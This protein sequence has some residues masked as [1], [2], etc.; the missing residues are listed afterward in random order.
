MALKALILRKKISEKKAELNTLRTAAA[1]FETREAEIAAS[2]EE[3]HT[4]EEKTV[5]EEA[6]DTFEKEKSENAEKDKALAD[7]IE[8]LENELKELEDAAPVATPTTET[9]EVRKDV[10]FMEL[11][12]RTKFSAMTLEQRSAF[13]ARDEIKEFVTRARDLLLQNRSVSG[14]ELTIPDNVLEFMRLEIYEGSKLIKHVCS[15]SVKGTARQNIMGDIPEAVWTEADGKIN[16]LNF[17]IS[18]AEVDGY[19]VA[20]FVAIPN[21]TIEDSDLALLSELIAATGRSIGIALDKAIL[22]GDGKKKP[23]GIVTRLSQTTKP[24]SYPVKAREWVDLH[25]SNIKKLPG[26]LS[27]AGFFA[28]LTIAAAA[29]KS[30]NSISGK[31]W[32]M[33]ETTKATIL[34]KGIAFN[35]AGAIVAAM[36]DRMPIVDGDIET[37][38]FIPDNDIIGGY[39]EKYLLAERSGATFALSEHAQ[40]VDDNTLAKGVA[41][42][43]GLPVIAESFVVI[44]INNAA[45]GTETTFAPDTANDASLTKLAIGSETLAPEFNS[46]K[47]EYTVT[48]SGTSA[49]IVATAT[50]A[51]AKV[52]LTYDGKRINNGDTVTF[53]QGTKNLVVKVANGSGKQTYTVAITKA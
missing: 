35:A 37:L 8:G 44:N 32:A 40:F 25:T 6:V 16:E 29:A 26:S 19:K 53:V 14:A 49:A 42:Y 48:A 47:T 12:T 15:K 9:A 18:Q 39:G 17:T 4:D 2:I 38:D 34:S 36:G 31:F 51:D 30:K 50:E 24:D 46:A 21:S 28:S 1:A 22:Y 52:T 33:N 5:V 23:L 27:D 20:G 45:A 13:A 43:D 11:N 3:A 7:E 41:R 10:K